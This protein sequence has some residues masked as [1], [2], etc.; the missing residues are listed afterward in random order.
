MDSLHLF[1]RLPIR[2]TTSFMLAAA[3]RFQHPR[4]EVQNFSGSFFCGS[5][6]PVLMGVR[7]EGAVVP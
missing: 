7:D 3:Q 1:G 5:P 6:D 4:Q 2:P